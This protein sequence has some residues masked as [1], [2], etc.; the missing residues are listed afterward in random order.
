MTREDHINA[1]LF[2]FR[3]LVKHEAGTQIEA[4]Y[5]DLNISS[6]KYEMKFNIKNNYNV[7]KFDIDV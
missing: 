1:G 4:F 3:L 5:Q 7:G 2:E 6:Q